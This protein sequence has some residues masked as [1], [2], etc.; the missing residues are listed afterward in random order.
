MKMWD[1]ADTII[2]GN[3]FLNRGN[4][5]DFAGLFANIASNYREKYL[6]LAQ[7]F[8]PIQMPDPVK[9]PE[10]RPEVGTPD[11]PSAP[12]DDYTPS[13]DTVA[14][15]KPDGAV[16]PNKT[17]GSETN[18]TGESNQTGETGDTEAPAGDVPVER[19]PD[20]TYYYQ[21]QA[22]LDYKLNL[23]FDLAAISRTVESIADGETTAIEELTAGGF[24]LHVG[25][26]I[27]G[28][29]RVRT[30]MTEMDDTSRKHEVTKAK[31]RRAGMFAAN[32]KDFAVK[33]FFK[34]ASRVHRS[35]KE[36]SRGA[37]RTAVN[38]FA[39]RFRLDNQFS[40][41]HL[42][43][44]NVQTEQVAS[45]SPDN[46]AGYVGSA[47]QVAE[48]GSGQMMSAFFGA[49]DSYLG[50]SEQAVL[51][52]VTAFFDAAAE[53]LGFS[54]AMVEQARTHL[55]DTISGFFDRVETALAG[56]ESRFVPQTEI[57]MPDVIPDPAVIEPLKPADMQDAQSLAT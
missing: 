54:G 43:R 35:L 38:K 26:D 55:T 49:V 32:S 18:A 7:K 24:G 56:M 36:Q 31:S 33:S 47:G 15:E 52:K 48:T 44:F 6:N 34:E 21:R 22:K 42:Q 2:V 41:A 1:A 57:P 10:P 13:R 3:A 5:M 12:V 27:K 53:D 20:G 23:E 25:F 8:N 14:A 46:V 51:D 30:N 45:Q 37:H 28:S 50:E 9:L 16:T 19:K 17:E 29:E 40:F 39:A 11:S 4:V